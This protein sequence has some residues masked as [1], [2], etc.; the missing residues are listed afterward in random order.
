MV[1]KGRIHREIRYFWKIFWNLIK[2]G[3]ELV[4]KIR[5]NGRFRKITQ[6]RI[7]GIKNHSIWISIR[8]E[9]KE[10]SREKFLKIGRLKIKIK[11][12]IKQNYDPKL[13]IDDTKWEIRGKTR[14]LTQDSDRNDP[15]NLRIEAFHFA[16]LKTSIGVQETNSP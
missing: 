13:Q 8:G 14:I 2:S 12:E 7:H 9:I 3:D 4:I 6:R 5:K 16:I 11:K 1:N 10:R 15:I